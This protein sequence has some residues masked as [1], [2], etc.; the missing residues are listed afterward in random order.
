MK[1]Y[2]GLIKAIGAYVGLSFLPSI[3]LA[4]SIFNVNYANRD[5]QRGEIVNFWSVENKIFS[6]RVETEGEF[7][8]ETRKLNF[9]RTLGGWRTSIDGAAAKDFSGDLYSRENNRDVF[10]FDQM[11]DKIREYRANGI[12]VNQIVLDN[13]PW[14]FQNDHTFVDQPN[15]VNYLRSTE[16]ETYGNAIPPDKPNVWSD[17]ISATTQRL[18]DEFGAATVAQWRFRVGSEIDTP[19]HWAGTATEFFNHYRRTLDA[20]RSV[21]PNAIVGVHFREAT[22]AAQRNGV[23]RLDYRGNAITSFGNRF[24]DWAARNNVDY[25]FFGVSYYPFFN[26][27]TGGLGGL[28]P[29][30]WYDDAVAPFKNNPNF[31]DGVPFEI[32]EYW[33]FT[34]FGQGVIVNVGTSHGSAFMVRLARMAYERNVRQINMWGHG[35]IGDL[36][37]P[38]RMA[39]GMLNTMVGERRYRYTS[40]QNTRNNNVLDAVF[41][42]N[43]AGNTPAYNAIISNYSHRP[44]YAPDSERVNVRMTLPVAPNTRY[45]YRV[46][47]YGREQS[48]F[49]QLKELNTHYRTNERDGGWIDNRANA[50]YGATRRSIA[51]SGQL[52]RSRLAQ[53][54]RDANT[55]VAYN[56]ITPGRWVGA[57]TAQLGDANGRSL[58]A[59]NINLE[60]FML[61]KVEVRLV[62]T[63][64]PQATPAPV[65]TNDLSGT[66]YKIKNIA[67]NRYWDGNASQLD[68][69]TSQSGFDKQWRFIKQGEYYNIDIR[70]TA[71]NNT[72]ILRTVGS[73]DSVIVTNLSPRNDADKRFDII[74]IANGVY[75]IRS[76][77]TDRFLEDRS[78]AVRPTSNRPGSNRNARWSLIRVGPE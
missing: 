21:L 25:D 2:R 32:H 76:T 6:G 8:G 77:N 58:A 59:I 35:S 14:D 36:Y 33:L 50:T 45:E 24:I 70:K 66:W 48:G 49:N 13:P 46:I 16:I 9:I 11:I 57:R 27:L 51:G 41:S 71:G 42:T 34:N 61:A 7:R 72:G 69:N 31:R 53:L 22:F 43:T 78:G 56:T 1:S 15:G 39:L 10:D 65:A 12:R 63:N 23:P 74:E 30:R 18:V 38:Q 67:T 26:R 44:A 55:L 47:P 52:R 75:S 28:D 54:E 68:T 20:V 37:S 60:S 64:E 19:G 73:S 4:Q 62:E 40:T 3:G 5:D 17:F 29:I